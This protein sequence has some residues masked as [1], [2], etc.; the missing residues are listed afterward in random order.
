[1]ACGCVVVSTK[2]GGPQDLIIDGHNGYL[3]EVGHY[4]A[5]IH[6]INKLLTDDDL[7]RRMSE[8]SMEIAQNFIWSKSSNL[9]E[10]ELYKL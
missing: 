4:G 2:C 3:V 8:N 5:I 1:M 9:L 6:Y 7:F 10:Q